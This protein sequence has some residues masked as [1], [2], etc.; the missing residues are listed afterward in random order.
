M[1][2]PDRRKSDLPLSVLA[3]GMVLLIAAMAGSGLVVLGRL[4]Q[5]LARESAAR[6]VLRQGRLLTGYLAAQPAVAQ[7]AAADGGW[8]DFARL[9][10]SLRAMEP[11]LR[12]VSVTD[13]DGVTIFHRGADAVDGDA[14][15]EAL[16]SVA[17]AATRAK[18][19]Q[20]LISTTEGVVPVVAFRLET[21]AG[22]NAARHVEIGMDRAAVAREEAVTV[23]AI[24]AMFRVSFVTVIVSFTACAVLVLWIMRREARRERLR[25]EEEHLAFSGIMANGIVHDFRNPMSSVKLDAQ[26]LLKESSR[27]DGPRPERVAELAERMR[28]TV[29]R[30]DSVFREFLFVSRP[31]APGAKPFSLS[32][33]LR[34]CLAMLTP[35]FEAAGVRSEL[36][37]DPPSITV[38]CHEPSVL[39]A[40]TNVIINA[41]QFAG[42]NGL[43]RISARSDGQRASVLISD[44]GPGV[45]PAEKKKVFDMFYSSRPGGT[46]LGLFM[47]RASLERCGGS[48]SLVHGDLHGACFRIVLPNVVKG[49]DGETNGERKNTGG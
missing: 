5:D 49:A 15:D 32:V 13:A 7:G 43:V 30:M 26:M 48:L 18:P 10:A 9:Y 47:A 6:N 29:D 23:R 22:S 41:V 1:N 42:T 33:M 35:R 46:G 31:A 20:K 28:E 27:P 21:G 38:N 14:T 11:S 44:T 12:Y 19:E 25:R 36:V 17:L 24:S 39:R 34:N 3:V 4:Q 45:G 16:R 2:I 37:C 40:V 8:M